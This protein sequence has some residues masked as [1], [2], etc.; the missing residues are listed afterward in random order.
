VIFGLIYFSKLK[1]GLLDLLSVCPPS[2]LCV[3][4]SLPKA[5]EPN[6]K[7]QHPGHAIECD[8]DDI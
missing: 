4:L 1:I 7:I 8:H 2:C 3:R 6:G 5:F